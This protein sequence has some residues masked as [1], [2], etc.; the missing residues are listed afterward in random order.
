[1]FK[2]I[3]KECGKAFDEFEKYM[4]SN[5]SLWEYLPKMGYWVYKCARLSPKML[6]GLLRA[7]FLEKKLY[8]MQLLMVI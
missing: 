4:L 8:Y 6:E 3:S 5:A 2:K 7:F 1:M